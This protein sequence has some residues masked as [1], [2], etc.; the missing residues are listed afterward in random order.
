MA[1]AP[2]PTSD[3]DGYYAIIE[4]HHFCRSAK[5]ILMQTTLYGLDIA[6]RVFQ[7]YWVEP[8]TGEVINRKFSRQK[9]IEFFPIA[10]LAR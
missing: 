2:P 3:I 1:W 6:K 10:L 8:E 5:E 9:L 7:L 4:V